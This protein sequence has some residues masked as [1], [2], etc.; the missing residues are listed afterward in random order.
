MNFSVSLQATIY[1]TLVIIFGSIL[2]LVWG[3]VFGIINF[4]TV[5]AVQPFIKL[6]FTLFR[7]G[8]I[9]TRVWVRMTLDPCYESIALQLSRMNG[10]MKLDV[11]GM[12]KEI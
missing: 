7:C 12:V 6:S 2:A 11:K 9:V 10:R 3:I 4:V 8:Y 5:F 1:Y